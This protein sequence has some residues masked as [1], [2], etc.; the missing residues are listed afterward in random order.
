MAELLENPRNFDYYNKKIL[1]EPILDEVFEKT[2]NSIDFN[3]SVSSQ[4]EYT[5]SYMKRNEESRFFIE[6]LMLI[7]EKQLK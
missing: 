7:W 1:Q 6:K 3:M 2:V 5:S 4:K